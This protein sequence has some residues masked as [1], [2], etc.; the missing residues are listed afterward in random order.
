MGRRSIS[1]L[2]REGEIIQERIKIRKKS[3]N[4]EKISLKFKNIKRKNIKILK[5]K[6]LK[7]L[8]MLNGI[9]SLTDKILKM[10][11]QKHPQANELIQEVLLQGPTEPFHQIVYE[12]MDGF[13][14]SNTNI[15][16]I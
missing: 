11:K 8:N 1:N 12:D 4:I 13:E 7:I 16:G 14:S 2:L 5:I 10:L 15:K 9:L 3:M 6:K